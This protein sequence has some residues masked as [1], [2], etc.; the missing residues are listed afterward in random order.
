MKEGPAVQPGFCCLPRAKGNWKPL[1]SPFV[2]AS[3]GKPVR[4]HLGFHRV[5]SK[6]CFCLEL[7]GCSGTTAVWVPGKR[8]SPAL[9]TLHVLL[10]HPLCAPEPSPHIAWAGREVCEKNGNQH[11]SA[12][13]FACFAMEKERTKYFLV[14]NAASSPFWKEAV[15]VLC[16]LGSCL[17]LP[18]IR[19]GHCSLL[20]LRSGTSRMSWCSGASP[21]LLLSLALY[22]A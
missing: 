11:Y 17:G 12:L 3:I 19:L 8:D 20:S 9:H 14:S 13:C 4:S 2:L 15:Q 10:G 21:A 18:G 22:C 1:Q 16:C 6:S 5:F 7:L